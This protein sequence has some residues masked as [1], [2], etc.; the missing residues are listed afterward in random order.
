MFKRSPAKSVVSL[1]T[2][3]ALVLWYAALGSQFAYA[4]A[5]TTL[6]DTMSS[7]KISTVSNHDILFTTPTGITTTQTIT[8]TFPG[9]FSI[10]ASFDFNDVDILVNGVQQTLAGS[11][12]ASTWGVVRTSA[13]LLTITAQTSGTPAAAGNTIRIK[14]G[15]NATQG[16]T[17]THQITNDSSN[18]SKS[19]TIGG[20]MADSGSISVY[21]VNDDTVALSATVNQSLSFA[22]VSATSTAFSN[23]IYFGTLG[24][25]A[26]KYA[27]ST[28]TSGDTTETIAHNLQV[29]T[30]AP[31]GY[32]IT[33]QGQTLTSQ[34]NAGN[35][36]DFIGGTAASSAA[37]TEQFGIRATKSG[38]TGATI[39]A[40]YSGGSTYGF[41]ATATTT[42]AFST[43]TSP[44]NTETYSLRYIANISALTEAGTY[45]ASLQYVATANY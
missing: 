14:L 5:L 15:T 29:S 28:N 24:S 9:S 26:A 42:S 18:G 8:V 6:S 43:G 35:T 45:T 39:D 10:P 34:Q 33:I 4:G 31:S 38:G 19:I 41:D 32:A 3:A 37:G 2:T 13:N 30:N 16:S 23:A 40:T 20:S 22:I 27:S 12:G 21:L 11:Q 25:G 44:T 7:V 1:V 36:I 17:G